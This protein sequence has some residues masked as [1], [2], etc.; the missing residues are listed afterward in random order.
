VKSSQSFPEHIPDR[1]VDDATCKDS[2]YYPEKLKPDPVSLSLQLPTFAHCGALDEVVRI[3]NVTDAY[4]QEKDT[5]RQADG[6]F[7]DALSAV[8]RH[9]G[10]RIA[11]LSLAS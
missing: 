8:Q 11:V 6:Q 1:N 9:H 5:Y 10:Y 4:A 2:S 3:Y 7:P